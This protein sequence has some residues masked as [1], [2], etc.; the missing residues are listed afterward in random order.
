V[1]FDAASACE[2]HETTASTL[3]NMCAAQCAVNEIVAPQQ[4]AS[5]P[6]AG[7]PNKSYQMLKQTH[8]VLARAARPSLRLSNQR[9]ASQSRQIGGGP[10]TPP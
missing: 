8:H 10:L 5:G 2:R 3:W 9:L 7:R 1:G 6:A 4:N